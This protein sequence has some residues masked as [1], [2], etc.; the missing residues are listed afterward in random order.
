[1]SELNRAMRAVKSKPVDVSA[2]LEMGRVQPQA[3]LLEEAVLG[4][5][6]IDRD[7]LPSVIEILKID[8]FYLPQHQIIFEV[9]TQLFQSSQPIDLLTVQEALKKAGKLE[10]VGGL[11]YLIELSNKVASSANIE[12]HA[13]II[14]QKFIQRE[15]IKVSNTIIKDAF[16]DSKDVLELLDDAER[17]L[18]EITDNNLNT[19][20]ESL[21][22]LVVKAQKEI[23]Y[24]GEKGSVTTGVTTGFR[25]LD[26]LTNGWQQSDLI[27]I[28]AR[29]GMGKTAF[30][31][32]L[33]KNAAEHNFPVAVFSLEMASVQLVQRIISMDSEIESGKL[34]NGQM[35]DYEWKKLHASVD[36]LA[37]VPIYIDDTPGIN[38]FE[39]RA[40][41]RR[42]KQNHDIKM[43]IIDYLQLMTG[44][45]TGKGGGGGNRE[46]EISSISRA[47]KALAKELHVP[48][49]AL[50][51]L[52]RAV[53]TRGGNK[54][55]M[56]SDLRES[57]AIE[58]DADI[59]TFIYRPGY[60]ELE[61]EEFEG[62]KDMAEIILAKH[63]NGGLGTVELRFQGQYTK[64]VE[65]EVSHNDIS[66][67]G[68]K[69]SFEADP[70][71]AGI[72]TR[73]S[74]MNRNEEDSGVGIEDIPF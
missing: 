40:K 38:I 43:I 69:G 47:L 53:E 61:G 49:I 39:L 67:F 46:Q 32:S 13:R 23:E 60:Y 66:G 8:S 54:R 11:N 56:L 27:I 3:T 52:S 19:G 28:A 71:A 55:P 15:L 44:A 50:S 9:M 42:L 12:F 70:F 6:L 10:E 36:R 63:R 37:E 68:V 58:Q 7:G 64:F 5:M 20:Y 1:M 34:R 18:Y 22:T 59:V 25:E 2:Q 45:P 26:K 33:A 74:R 29:P 21:S 65:K 14:A 57:G 4:A 35:E 31:L 41:C 51:Q 16:E 24:L 30:T 17:A 62:D 73:P 48:V 72:I